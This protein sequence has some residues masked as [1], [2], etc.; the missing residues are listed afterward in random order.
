[1]SAPLP[2]LRVNHEKCVLVGAMNT[3][4]AVP[5]VVNLGMAMLAT[6]FLI[7]LVGRDEL[8]LGSASLSR[9]NALLYQLVPER[10]A[11]IV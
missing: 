9:R 5:V 10:D 2:Q 4:S 8:D 11:V 1:M 7:S 3:S 6:L